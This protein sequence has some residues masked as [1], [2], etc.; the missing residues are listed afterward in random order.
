MK[1]II[2]GINR[3]GGQCTSEYQ[4]GIVVF[5]MANCLLWAFLVW[6]KGCLSSV[7][8]KLISGRGVCQF[9]SRQTEV[10]ASPRYP[11]FI[12]DSHVSY[13]GRVLKSATPPLNQRL[14]CLRR[15]TCTHLKKIYIYIYACY[16]LLSI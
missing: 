12:G 9:V 7:T 2:T 10:S 11:P 16:L 4:C 3:V 8:R 15:K 1:G 6:A 13:R 14:F 5:N